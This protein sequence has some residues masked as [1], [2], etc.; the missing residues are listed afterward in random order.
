MQLLGGIV[1]DDIRIEPVPVPVPPDAHTAVHETLVE[2]WSSALPG[3]GVLA[4]HAPAALEAHVQ[5][6]GRAGG[7]LPCA[8]AVR[9]GPSKPVEAFPVLD[10]EAA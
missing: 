4:G 5:V 6:H 3:D 1:S 7:N 2:R 9:R 8:D 10:E